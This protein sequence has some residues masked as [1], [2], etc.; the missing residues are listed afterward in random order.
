MPTCPRRVTAVLALL[1]IALLSSEAGAQVRG[2]G[3]RIATRTKPAR[4][5]VSA[6]PNASTST[7]GEASLYS[8]EIPEPTFPNDVWLVH[9]RWVFTTANTAATK[10]SRLRVGATAQD[11]CSTTVN[12]PGALGALMVDCQRSTPG[13]AWMGTL[14][15]TCLG[16]G[17]GTGIATTLVSD[18]DF[19]VAI[20]ISI[21]GETPGGAGELTLS[22]VRVDGR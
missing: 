2:P 12:T 19:S 5:L 18:V 10:T 3:I 9:V 20:P 8:Y 13:V 7:M 1:G 4:V 16:T 22:T 21:T 6:A 17:T 15:C 11:V 14:S